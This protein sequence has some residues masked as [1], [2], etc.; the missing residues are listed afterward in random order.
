M[1]TRV[2]SAVLFTAAMLSLAAC[3]DDKK[4]DA[5][6]ATP[7]TAAASAPAATTAAAAASGASDKEICEGVNK[8]G[9]AM[10]ADLIAA[11]AKAN[12]ELPPVAD[13]K[14]L[15]GAFNTAVLAVTPADSTSKAGVAALQM[16][17]DSTKIAA[18]ADPITAMEDPAYE[19]A[20]NDLEAACK[21]V[22]VKFIN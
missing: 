10:K 2:T 4:S 14:K 9:E 3:S 11:M 8:A 20:G 17:A 18:A 12:G 13:V 19:K 16:A 22:G 21:A 7:A 1:R 6:A 5:G 15:L